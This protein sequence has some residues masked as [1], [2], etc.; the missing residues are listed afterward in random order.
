MTE[1][2]ARQR[3]A[4]SR[5]WWV[6]GLGVALFLLYCAWILGPYLRSVFVRD[7]SVTSWAQFA[8]APIAGDIVSEL[9][10]VTS[11]VGA[12]GRVAVIRND[13]LLREANLV[14]ALEGKLDLARVRVDETKKLIGAIERIKQRRASD[15]L[16]YAKVFRAQLDAHIRS[17]E[18]ELTINTSHMSV[19]RDIVARHGNPAPGQT[20][21]ATALDETRV[22]MTQLELER[23]RIEAKLDYAKVRRA[24]TEDGI[25][26]EADGS[27]PNWAQVTDIDLDVQAFRLHVELTEAIAAHKEAGAEHKAAKA[28][29]SRLQEAV[30]TVP[31]GAFIE[32]IAVPRGAT[33]AAGDV[34]LTWVDCSVRLVD[35]PVSDAE[36]PLIRPGMPASVIMEGDS[37]TYKATVLLTRGSTATLGR[38][39]LAAVSKGRR[40]GVAQVILE[41]DGAQIPEGVCPVG[42]A[43]YVRF[44]DVGLIDV[45]RARLRL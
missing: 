44:P 38:K 1:P 24:A 45:I 14:A 35:V 29:L 4:T 32:S 43:A 18:R 36:L 2:S 27:D 8:T 16:K 10:T 22:R 19:L 11:T 31:P 41:L 12:N 15:K 28:N 25:F 33:V 6:V 13:R 3:S 20:T 9:P 5:T 17:L 39:T 34:L 37:R 7:S 42:R 26:M 40:P 21:S 23:A 30:I